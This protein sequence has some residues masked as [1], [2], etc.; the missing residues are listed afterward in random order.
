MQKLSKDEMKNIT[1]W[2]AQLKVTGWTN[3]TQKK[4]ATLFMQ[5]Q[6]FQERKRP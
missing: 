2:I 1:G 5:S 4:V 6:V 3:G